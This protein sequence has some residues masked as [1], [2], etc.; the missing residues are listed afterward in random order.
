VYWI[1]SIIVLIFIASAITYGVLTQYDRGF[2]SKNGNELYYDK[3]DLPIQFAYTSEVPV[4]YL[5][6]FTNVISELNERI[7]FKLFQ[8]T[9]IDWNNEKDGVEGT[10]NVL[11][12]VVKSF[13]HNPFCGGTTVIKS[14]TR[15]ENA[16]RILAV[17]IKIGSNLT[18]TKL[19]AA[20]KHEIGHA[21]GLAHDDKQSS[22]MHHYTGEDSLKD[23]TEND[24]NRLRK[25]YR[26]M[27]VK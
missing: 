20:I 1:V 27:F 26:S 21:L 17:H 19:V 12:D 2:L 25:K 15:S 7:G 23:F 10:I 16:G 11:V 22:V 5:D 14:D 8:T 3:E 18:S 9:M 4:Q 6:T 24:I 13:D